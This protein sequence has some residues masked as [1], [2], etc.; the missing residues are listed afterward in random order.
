MSKTLNGK[1][2]VE[3]ILADSSS[4]E[5]VVPKK[6]TKHSKK[7]AAVNESTVE[8]T[9]M[10]TK[11]RKAS[12]D[13]KA[14]TKKTKVVAKND[15]SDEEEVVK[16]PKSKGKVAPVKQSTKKEESDDSSDEEESEEVVKSST[17]NKKNK[18]VE[19]KEEVDSDEEE[20][21][22]KK[23]V[24][25]TQNDEEADTET[26]AELFVKNMSWNST[27]DSLW[28]AF[29]KFGAVANIKLLYD[30]NTGKPRGIG[31]ISFE[32]RK[33]AKA[34]MVG[35]GEVDGRTINCSWSNEKPTDAPNRAFAKPAYNNN[36]GGSSFPQ[37]SQ[38]DSHSIFIGNLGFKTT[39]KGVTN[40]FSDCGNVVGV[41]IAK[42]EDGSYKG[43]AHLD[44]DSA[45]AV[46]LAKKKAGQSLDGRELRVDASIPRANKG[47]GGSRGGSYGRQY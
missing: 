12:N 34:A 32:S 26:H 27:E 14:S 6:A 1:K 31:F 46:E 25:H 5:V 21:V 20:V 17:K 10:L 38:G 42:N 7:H 28:E 13:L 37:K 22:T 16:Q 23:T 18:I 33:E 43:F 9:E 4:D 35:I 47:G 29:S 41:R 11:K 36:N 44:F 30:K 39:E 40:F 15:D 45:D 3:A 19:K 8:P 24:T 2:K